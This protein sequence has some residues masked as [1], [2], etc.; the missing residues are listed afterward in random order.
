MAT[1]PIILSDVN[2]A[3]I[4]DYVAVKQSPTV[5]S[6]TPAAG[7]PVI[8]GMT[9]E[10]KTVSFSD[11]PY[12]VLDPNAPVAIRNVPIADIQNL[13]VSDDTL[14]SAVTSGTVPDTQ[15]NLITEKLNT[16]FAG[17]NLTGTIS[18]N[19]TSV[20]LKSFNNLGLFRF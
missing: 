3:K 1:A 15:L 17:S 2:L 9:I 12:Y 11:V 7:T 5:I 20:I 18:P 6:Q 4:G 19:D 14:K 8:E 16:G 13:V 10:V